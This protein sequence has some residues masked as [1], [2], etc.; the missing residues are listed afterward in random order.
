MERD[1]W[2]VRSVVNECMDSW[3]DTIDGSEPI[4]NFPFPAEV[5][6]VK[7]DRRPELASQGPPGRPVSVA[8]INVS[9]GSMEGADGRLTDTLSPAGDQDDALGKFCIVRHGRGLKTRTRVAG[10]P[11]RRRE[12]FSLYFVL[13]IKGVDS[14]HLVPPDNRYRRF[15]GPD[16]ICKPDTFVAT[17][18]QIP[19]HDVQVVDVVLF[20]SFQ[21]LTIP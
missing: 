1:A 21:P 9:A 4:N 11:K 12:R 8:E 18:G 14:D 13:T 17:V 20:F 15:A 10:K 7:N 16:S 3:R 5:D 19:N 6:G 2:I